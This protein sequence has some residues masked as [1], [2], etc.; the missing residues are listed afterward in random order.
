MSIQNYIF[1]IDI[2]NTLTSERQCFANMSLEDTRIKMRNI[3]PKKGIEILS[4]L[5][6]NIVLITGRGSYFYDDTVYW[7]RKQDVPFT[8]LVMIDKDKYKSRLTFQEYVRYK[9]NAYL[10]NNVHFCLE[11]DDAIINA[12]RCY[13][14]KASK[15]EDDFKRSLYDLFI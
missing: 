2:D 15:V 5:D 8:K 11:D 12:V 3:S 9:L 4:I 6:L 14:I 7:L 13:G 1:G 10:E